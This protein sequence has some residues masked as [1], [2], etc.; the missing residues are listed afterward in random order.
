MQNGYIRMSAASALRRVTHGSHGQ[1]SAAAAVTREDDGCSPSPEEH[2]THALC[3]Q[4]ITHML[5][6]DTHNCF[7]PR[8][9]KHHG[10]ILSLSLNVSLLV[11]SESSEAIL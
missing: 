10:Q 7:H 11:F 4:A 6:A 3:T 5:C 8:A 1:D 9:V 2:Y